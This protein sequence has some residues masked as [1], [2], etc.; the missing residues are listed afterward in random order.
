MINPLYG[1]V[2]YLSDN[3]RVMK[4]RSTE[5]NP[6]RKRI[7][8]V[9]LQRIRSFLNFL[10]PGITWLKGLLMSMHSVWMITFA[11]LWL[12]HVNYMDGFE[13]MN[14][15]FN[16]R[17]FFKEYVFKSSVS[18]ES[19]EKFLFINTSRNN[20]LLPYDN[21]NTINTVITD[22]AVLA[23]KLKILNENQDKVKYVSATYF[24]KVHRL[25][26]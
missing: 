13:F 4:T 10:F 1:L 21:D 24:S 2:L 17:S 26:K 5:K 18:S 23:S 9:P 6:D 25:I 22:R 3:P 7:V 14:D 11:L 8:K 15:F 19:N 12:G 20:E 16:M